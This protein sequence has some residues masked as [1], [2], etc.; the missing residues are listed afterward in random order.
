MKTIKRSS[1]SWFKDIQ[2]NHGNEAKMES[3][4]IQNQSTNDTQNKAKKKTPWRGWGGQEDEVLLKFYLRPRFFFGAL[5]RVT[6]R[7]GMPYHA[8]PSQASQARGEARSRGEARRDR[9]A[10]QKAKA[11]A[12]DVHLVTPTRASA[13]A[14]NSW[15]AD[16][17]RGRARRRRVVSRTTYFFLK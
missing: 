6:R 2:E 11:K 16:P 15:T 3:V 9:E 8:K 17:R 7:Q 13:V 1:F 10:A 12:K 14:D 5:I 4:S